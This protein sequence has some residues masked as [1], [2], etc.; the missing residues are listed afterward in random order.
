VNDKIREFLHTIL[1]IIFKISVGAHSCA[2]LSRLKA[3][4]TAHHHAERN[5]EA[6]H[7]RGKAPVTSLLFSLL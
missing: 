1:S 7:F 6:M 3:A 4:P 2:I 5:H